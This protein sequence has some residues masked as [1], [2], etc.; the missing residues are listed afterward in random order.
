M[1]IPLSN[2]A[3]DVS[4][5]LS[6]NY[7]PYLNHKDIPRTAAKSPGDSTSMDS[8]K[9]TFSRVIYLYVEDI[10][11]LDQMEKIESA[12]KKSGLSVI[13]RSHDYVAIRQAEPARRL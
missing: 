12:Y 8:D 2:E 11:T 4:I 7:G 5:F 6:D 9:L 10:L 3:F 1:Y 13:I